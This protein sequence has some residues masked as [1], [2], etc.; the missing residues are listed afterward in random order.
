MV[1]NNSNWSIW[2]MD[3]GEEQDYFTDNNLLFSL[4]VY[5]CNRHSARSIKLTGNLFVKTQHDYS[6]L[7]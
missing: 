2:G 1:F 3:N 4:N 5:W 6:V 7:F